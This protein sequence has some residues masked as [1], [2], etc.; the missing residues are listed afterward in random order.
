MVVHHSCTIIF[1]HSILCN[2]WNIK[3]DLNLHHCKKIVGKATYIM[4]LPRAVLKELHTHTSLTAPTM[5]E[6]TKV[7]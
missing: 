5:N 7:C 4:S 2:D 6:I 3:I 1:T